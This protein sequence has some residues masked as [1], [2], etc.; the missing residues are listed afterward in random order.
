MKTDKPVGRRKTPGT[1]QA[2]GLRAR[3][4][5]L[6]EAERRELRDEAMRLYYECEQKPTAT[7]RR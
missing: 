6:T 2:A 3:C 7:H 5:K 1:L 4:N